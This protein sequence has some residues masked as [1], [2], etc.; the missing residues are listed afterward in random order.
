M[1]GKGQNFIWIL[2]RNPYIAIGGLLVLLAVFA[3]LAAPLLTDYDPAQMEPRARLEAPSAEHPMGTDNYGR[4]VMSR[5]LFGA[6]NSLQ[7]GF[8]VVVLSVIGGILVGLVAGYLPKADMIISRVIDGLMA[9]PEIIIAITLAAVLGAGMGNI[10]IA[11]A[12]AYFTRMAR[13]VRGSTLGVKDME[14]VESARVI[15]ASNIYIVFRYILPN[16]LSPIVVQATFVFAFSILVESTL[17]FLGVGI[18]PPAP[19]WGSMLS[20]GRDFMT[21]AP[22]LVLYPGASIVIASLGFNLL[23]DGLRDYLDPKL[24]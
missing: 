3:A 2:K 19:S 21:V 16:I 23:G 9:F 14:Y 20:D 24:K 15:G 13:I 7:V 4:D 22:W 12:F 11:M 5:V 17:S 8:S 10:V 1:T 18:R 6:R